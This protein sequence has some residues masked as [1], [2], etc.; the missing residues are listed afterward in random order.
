MRKTTS[1][2]YRNEDDLVGGCPLAAAMSLIGGR[3]KILLLWYVGHGLD[4]YGA[5]LRTIPNISGKMLYQQ[6]REL[7]HQGLVVRVVEGRRVRY[8]L[9]S[10]GRSMLEPLSHLEN[11]SREHAIGER[12]LRERKKVAPQTDTGR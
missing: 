3:W 2:N 5:L 10:L 9:S 12:L 6:L 8:A 1:I 4:R 11:W 7:E